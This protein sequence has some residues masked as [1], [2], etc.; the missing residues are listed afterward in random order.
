MF[1]MVQNRHE[2]LKNLSPSRK[3]GDIITHR[4]LSS[5]FEI[6]SDPHA[7]VEPE[8]SQP[9]IRQAY[10][11]LRPVYGKRVFVRTPG[12]EY[13][14]VLVPSAPSI[15]LLYYSGGRVHM[16]LLSIEDFMPISS[17]SFVFETDNDMLGTHHPYGL[18]HLVAKIRLWRAGVRGPDTWRKRE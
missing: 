12:S 6:V 2:Y 16:K 13:E 9:R 7:Q 8:W 14:G 4:M 17:D 10:A 15:D 18:E 11:D 5:A 3:A 1:Y